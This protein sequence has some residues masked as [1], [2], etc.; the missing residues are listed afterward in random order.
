MTQNVY[1]TH[2]KR[3]PI[4][5]FNGALSALTA[6]E[7]ATPLVSYLLKGSNLAAENIDDVFFG[8]VLQAGQGQNMA[9]Q[10]ARNAVSDSIPGHTI[11]KVCGSGL[12]SIISAAQAIKAGDASAIIA[13][14]AESMSQS[15]YLVPKART[16]FKMGHQ[17]LVDSMIS[18]GLWDCFNDY[19][20]GVTAENIVRKHAISR[21]AQDTFAAQSQAKAIKAQA[22]GKFDAEI[23][24]VSIPQRKGDPKVVSVDECPRADTTADSLSLLRAAFEKD[25]TVTAGNSSSIND[26]AAAVLLVSEDLLAEKNLVP[27]ARVVSYASVGI[28]PA[29]MGLGPVKAIE[30]ALSLAGWSQGDVDL[31]ELNEA[32]AAQSLGVLAECPFDTD[33]VNVNGGAIALG[34]P[35]GA[36]GTRIVVTLLHEMQ[37]RH[38]KKGLAALCI[39]GG[40]GIAIC[41]ER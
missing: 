13:G 9:R 7:L 33:K 17:A 38:V 20:M 10:I 14:G 11:N 23:L 36:S 22:D 18:D 25:G 8:N 35:I 29:V 1:I 21:E 39:G 40:M 26:G 27:L 41:L 3:T 16:G 6:V 2:A 32:F 34:H 37:K 28:D 30:K 4:G 19:H 24:P 15:P 5:K 31:V 12:Q